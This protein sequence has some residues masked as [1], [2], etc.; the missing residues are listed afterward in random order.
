MAIDAKWSNNSANSEFSG[1][2]A[3]MA[4]GMVNLTT[5][6]ALLYIHAVYVEKDRAYGQKEV[7]AFMKECLSETLAYKERSVRNYLN[8]MLELARFAVKT[9]GRPD[10]ADTPQFWSKV[11]ECQT[12]VESVAVVAAELCRMG[13]DTQARLQAMLYPEKEAKKQKAKEQKARDQQARDQQTPDQQAPDQQAPDQKPV[14]REE[15]LAMLL[16]LPAE[17]QAWV[18]KAYAATTGQPLALTKG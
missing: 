15:V 3:A 13:A 8:D 14:T 5:A 17:D 10:A 7:R 6:G 18:M 12:F 1:A 4:Q 2:V 16:D 9:W 11:Y